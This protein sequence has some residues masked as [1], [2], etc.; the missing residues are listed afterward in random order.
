MSRTYKHIKAC[1]NKR[2]YKERWD[3]E[4]VAFEY[5][6]TTYYS[7]ELNDVPATYIIRTMWLDKPGVKTKK[8]KELDTEDHW[9]TTP[10]W[11]NNLFHTRPIRGKFRSFCRNAVRSSTGT[12]EEMLEPEDSKDPH[13]YYW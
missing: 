7:P 5:E 1:K 9:M 13:K 2:Y 3:S 6:G 10:S 8:R 11:W 4:R 12:L